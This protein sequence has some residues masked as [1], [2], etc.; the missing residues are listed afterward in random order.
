MAVNRILVTGEELFLN[1]HKLLFDSL[2][3][4]VDELACLPIGHLYEPQLFRRMMRLAY[5]LSTGTSLSNSDGFFKN[6]KAFVTR[7]LRIESQIKRLDP[8]PDLVLHIFALCCPFWNVSDI[9]YAIYLD[10]TTAL[11]VKNH[12][13]FVPFR[14]ASALNE[15]LDCERQ[16]YQRA[17]YIFTMSEVVKSSAIEDYGVDPQK[18]TVV[19]SSGNRQEAE[20]AE[21]S[22]G[23]KQ[24][25]FNGSDFER[26]GGELVL[27]TFKQLKHKIPEAKL[28]IIGKKLDINEAGV[29]NPG[30]IKSASELR[31]LFLGSDLVFAP[32]TCDPFPTFVLEAM[33]YGVPAVVSDR[34][35]MPEIV[36]DGKTG[37]VLNHRNANLAAEQIEQ[38][39]SDRLTLLSMSQQGKHRITTRFNWKKIANDI[40]D[41]LLA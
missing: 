33:S 22:F 10:Y 26:K 20:P 36:E 3:V 15:W 23:S 11:A 34:D 41:I 18:I 2:S 37:I 25:L 1:R 32:A 7:S 40:A 4:R 14:S 21:K 13:P 12:P 5:C 28:V 19:G 38:L 8:T 30:I 24:I 35:G 6:A 39:L 9:P 17:K 16:A 31:D 29:E 27:A